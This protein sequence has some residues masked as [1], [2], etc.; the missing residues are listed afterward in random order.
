[1]TTK[2]PEDERGDLTARLWLF[3][4]KEGG[5]WIAGDIGEQTGDENVSQLLAGMKRNGMV[6]RYPI[7]PNRYAYGVTGDCRVPRQVSVQEIAEMLK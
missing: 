3:L 5:R 2:R 7:G 6:R 4:L 1:M